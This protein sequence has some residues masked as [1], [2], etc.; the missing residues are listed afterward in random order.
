MGHIFQVK[1]T[2]DDESR[3]NN[4]NSN[5]RQK[6]II[7]FPNNIIHVKHQTTAAQ[8]NPM[9]TSLDIFK[10]FYMNVGLKKNQ[11]ILG[12]IFSCLHSLVLGFLYA[13]FVQW[14]ILA[15]SYPIPPPP[16]LPHHTHFERPTCS[17]MLKH[18]V[19]SCFT[20]TFV[21]GTFLFYLLVKNMTVF[22][23]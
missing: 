22:K 18:N 23:Q 15:T 13:I 2:N 3:H 1:L 9:E 10:Y 19:P 4:F 20:L 21:V 6:R 12:S 11:S 14:S 16:K 8:K 5:P 7:T 17:I